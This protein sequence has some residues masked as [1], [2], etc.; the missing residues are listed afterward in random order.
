MRLSRTLI[1]AVEAALPRLGEAGIATRVVHARVGLWNPTTVRHALREL[2]RQGRAG[3]SGRDRH[4]HYHRAN[5]L[6][7]RPMPPPQFLPLPPRR[8]LA[9]RDY[10]ERG[11]GSVRLPEEREVAEAMRRQRI[12][13]RDVDAAALIAEE[14]LPGWSRRPRNNAELTRAAFGDPAPGRNRA[15][16]TGEKR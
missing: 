7:P 10:A 3:F 8:P 5:G 15:I 11:D 13:Y 16:H 6:A 12:R 14:R 9:W 4:R 2:V 1:D